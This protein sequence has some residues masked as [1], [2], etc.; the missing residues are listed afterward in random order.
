M[1]KAD[2]AFYRATGGTLQPRCRECHKVVARESARRRYAVRS[3]AD[4][5]R[6]RQRHA[7]DPLL[8]ARKRAQAK[9]AYRRRV[10]LRAWKR[11]IEKEAA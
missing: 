6:K 7:T 5:A 4:K 8:R 11:A 10:E 2:Y 1:V 9:R 3:V